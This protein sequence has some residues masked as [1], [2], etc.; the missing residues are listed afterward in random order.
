MSEVKGTTL[1]VVFSEVQRRF[2]QWRG[3]KRPR[4][5]IPEDLIYLN[6]LNAFYF[7]KKKTKK[8]GNNFIRNI[9]I[10]RKIKPLGKHYL[11]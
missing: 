6:Y 2:E 7:L 4:A 10:M 9:K 8:I 1:P 11:K 3:S 5:R